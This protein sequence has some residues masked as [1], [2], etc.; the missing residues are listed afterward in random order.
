MEEG[1][2]SFVQQNVTLE[3]ITQLCLVY[4][5]QYSLERS[6]LEDILVCYI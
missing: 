1:S 6:S 5:N 4:H 2:T 3:L